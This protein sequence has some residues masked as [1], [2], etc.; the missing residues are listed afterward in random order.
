[1]N[2]DLKADFIWWV[3]ETENLDFPKTGDSFNLYLWL[4]VAV[5]SLF[6]VILLCKKLKKE[7]RDNEG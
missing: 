2:R 5:G 3:E 6:L 7:D 1:M 4:C